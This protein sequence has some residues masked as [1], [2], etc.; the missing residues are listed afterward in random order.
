M[1]LAFV[2]C[3]EPG[4]LEAQGVMLFESIRAFAGR[5]AGAPILSFQPREPEP[6]AR[7]TRD[8]LRRLEVEHRVEPLNREFAAIPVANKLFATAWAEAHLDVD[9]VVF[10]DSDTFFCGEP[11]ELA[12]SPDTAAAVR[13]ANKKNV[14]S[15]GPD[16]RKDGYWQKVYALC[17]V[18]EPPFVET[19]VDRQRV[20]A[21][22]NAGLMA[23]RRSEGLAERWLACFRSLLEANHLPYNGVKNADQVALAAALASVAE[24]VD[25]L[26]PRYNYPL[27]KRAQL[28]E[29]WR[30]APLEALRHV[31]YFRWFNKPGFLDAIDPP[32]AADSPLRAWLAERLPLTPFVED[33]SR[34]QAPPVRSPAR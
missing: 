26:D 25:V 4:R 13:P 33:P 6:L 3:V 7:A 30:D 15:S 21:Y 29:P 14:A 24:R 12:L 2:A 11:A 22:W 31:H 32:L 1:R 16:D 10:L 23:F 20:R 34:K 28:P 27:P 8:A 17:G 9:V 19:T 18:P 5:F